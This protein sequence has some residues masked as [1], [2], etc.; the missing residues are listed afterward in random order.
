MT[1][2]GWQGDR[3]LAYLRAGLIHLGN[4]PKTLWI[5]DLLAA[6][7]AERDTTL[8]A[9]QEQC[10][11]GRCYVRWIIPDG[12]K[13]EYRNTVFALQSVLN[14]MSKDRICNRP[15]SNTSNTSKYVHSQKFAALAANFD[16]RFPRTVV[17]N[18]SVALVCA[19]TSSKP[20]VIKGISARKSICSVLLADH[21][22][23]ARKGQAIYLMQERILGPDVRVHLTSEDYVAE[24]AVSIEVDYRFAS[25]KRFDPMK[26]PERIHR[27]CLECL[28]LEE[29]KFAGLDFKLA[30]DGVWYFLEMN[31]S[32]AFQGYDRR[33]GGRIVSMLKDWFNSR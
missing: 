14:N 24:L 26:L 18:S 8:R 21:I 11:T 1:L 15:R 33:A 9:L 29:L 28:R 10:E 6:S 16:V 7:E 5:E 31:G 17:S 22:D 25:Q 2:I 27:F 30:G 4:A 20:Y 23:A 3:T 12:L 19:A 13:S 32:P